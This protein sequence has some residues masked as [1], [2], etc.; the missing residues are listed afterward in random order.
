MAT[1]TPEREIVRAQARYVRTSARKARLVLEHIR[2]KSALEAQTILAFHTR[3]AAKDASKV[4]KSAIANADNNNG[5]DAEDMVV[6]AAYAD[7]G[8]TL[9]RWRPARSRPREPHREAHVSHHDPACRRQARRDQA[10]RPAC[11]CSGTRGARRRSPSRRWTSE[12]VVED[13]ATEAPAAEARPRSRKAQAQAKAPRQEAQGRRGGSS[14]VRRGGSRRR[15]RG[16][17]LTQR[18]NRERGRRPD[19]G[20]PRARGRG[21]RAAERYQ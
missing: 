19:R 13:V 7:E 8:P 12:P 17:G 21:R 18:P 1:A 11:R 15:A 9:K 16:R 20:R 6:V 14:S 10:P 5:Y 3:A 4:L 2:G